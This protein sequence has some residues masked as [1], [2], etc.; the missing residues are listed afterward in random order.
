[1]NLKKY[2]TFSAVTVAIAAQAALWAAI[3]DVI[4]FQGRL[5]ESNGSPVT[6][7]KS[8]VFRLFAADTGGSSVYS[9]TDSVTP[10]S[11]GIYNVVLGQN[12]SLA[13]VD[14]SNPLWIEVTVNGE[15]LTPRY[16]LTSTPYA[17]RSKS[18]ESVDWTDITNIPTNISTAG[19]LDSSTV[20]L[21]GN[22]FNAANKL[23]KLDSSGKLP[24]LDGSAL[25]NLSFPNTVASSMTFNAPVV[26][27]ST[28]QLNGGML[29]S[30]RTIAASTT[31]TT[32]DHIILIDTGVGAITVTLPTAVG[33]AGRQY[34]FKRKVLSLNLTTIQAPG[35]ETIDGL[36]TLSV[37]GSLSTLN[38]VIVISDGTNW[39]AL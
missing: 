33:N 17:F 29:T 32:S 24:V 19:N 37:A 7:Q 4:N 10:D 18:A 11:N 22:T 3:P 30:I 2:L 13:G 21:Q 27:N 34:V 15:T 39:F 28:L 20:T 35:S 26:M 6:T 16:K 38:S 12:V 36:G 1:M 5:F 9:E 8:I 31:L 25:T 23:V 14:F